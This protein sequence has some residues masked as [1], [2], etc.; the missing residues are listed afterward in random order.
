MVALRQRIR[1]KLEH[2]PLWQLILI[3]TWMEL[4]TLSNGEVLLYWLHLEAPPNNLIK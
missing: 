4:S 3:H 2:L 1:E